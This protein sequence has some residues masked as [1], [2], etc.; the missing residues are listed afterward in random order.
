MEMSEVEQL[1]KKVAYKKVFDK[2]GGAQFTV[3]P[4]APGSPCPGQGYQLFYF[5]DAQNK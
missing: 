5:C 4:M 1:T 3:P 2:A